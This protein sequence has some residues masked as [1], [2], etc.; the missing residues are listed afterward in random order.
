MIDQLWP[1]GG[2]EILF[3]GIGFVRVIKFE[4]TLGQVAK[5]IHEIGQLLTDMLKLHVYSQFTQYSL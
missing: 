2:C 5:T 1:L 3:K 4:D